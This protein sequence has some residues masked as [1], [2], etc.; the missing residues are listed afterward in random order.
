METF[1]SIVQKESEYRILLAP[2]NL[3]SL[4]ATVVNVLADRGIDVSELMIER[5]SG[6]TTTEQDVLH[7]LC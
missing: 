7:D 5:I 3:S 6:E 4:S 1:Y 2:A